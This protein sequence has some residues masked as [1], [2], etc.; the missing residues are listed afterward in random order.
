MVAAGL[1]YAQLRG[2]EGCD[3]RFDLAAADRSGA[4]EIIENVTMD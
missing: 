2:V 1:R 4:L 3:M